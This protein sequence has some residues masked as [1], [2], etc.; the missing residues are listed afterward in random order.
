MRLGALGTI[1]IEDDNGNTIPIT[2]PQPRAVLALLLLSAGHLVSVDRIT[3]VLWPPGAEQP[4]GVK[5]AVQACVSHLRAALKRLDGVR[6]TWHETG[7]ILHVN[8][9]LVDV[10]R[11]REL[12]G[13]ARGDRDPGRRST[14]L[15]EA[16]G[17][18][19]GTKALADV[20]FPELEPEVAGLGEEYA[21]ALECRVQADLDLGREERLVAELVTHTGRHPER[22][23]LRAHL[24]TA[25][26]RCGRTAEASQAYLDYRRWLADEHGTEPGA[27]LR[28]LHTQLL[29]RSNSGDERADTP[30]PTAAGRASYLTVA[31]TVPRVSDLDDPLLLGVHPAPPLT[32]TPQGADDV[33]AYVARDVDADLGSALRRSGFVLVV[34]AATAGKTRAA[35]HAMRTELTDHHVF[36]PDDKAGLTAAVDQAERYDDCVLWLDDLE[37]YLGAGGLTRAEISRFLV[38]GRHRVIL[39]TLR[40]V[41]DSRYQHPT[42]K[43]LLHHAVQALKMARRV[44][45]KRLFSPAERRRAGNL[46]D[47]DPRLARS[48]VT[49]DRYGIAESLAAGPALRDMW[50]AA[51]AE[52]SDQYGA[53]I[54]TAAIDCRRAGLTR[55]LTR[56]LLFELAEPAW[57]RAGMA[58]AQNDEAWTWA[59]RRRLGTVALLSPDGHGGGFTVFEYL[60][61]AVV[62]QTPTPALTTAVLSRMVREAD[63]EEAARLGGTAIEQGEFDIAVAAFDQAYQHQQSELGADHPETLTNRDRR[64]F[65]LRT[66]GLPDHAAGEHRAV[67]NARAAS[68]GAEH[69][70]TL[71][72][73][74]NFGVALYQAGRWP[75]AQAELATVLDARRRVLAEDDPDIGRSLSNLAPVLMDLGRWSEAERLAREAVAFRTRVHGLDDRNTLNSRN[76]LGLVLQ[77]LGHYAEAEAEHATTLDARERLLRPDHPDVLESR[78]NRATALR[79]LD[80]AEEAEREHR[81]VLRLR[82]KMLGEQ[83][84]DTVDARIHL[85]ADLLALGRVAEAA[86]MSELAIAAGTETYGPSH[87]YTLDAHEVH[88]QALIAAGRHLEA[89]DELAALTQLRGRVQGDEHPYTLACELRWAVAR[90]LLGEDIRPVLALLH[91][92]ASRRLDA[93]H[94]LVRAI[95][96][97]L[98]A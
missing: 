76:N 2:K 98:G 65:A 15:A 29:A 42:A 37:H 56:E 73:R 84:Y 57:G 53:A 43:D 36:A 82:E 9:A 49:A 20:A 16:L 97:A 66:A 55:P 69:P 70:L 45:L 90:S 80:R 85:A 34:G 88:A 50:L 17:L 5:N 79:H 32:G 78:H 24:L 89:A 51:Q 12:V 72:S 46:A 21:D 95:I 91:T 40:L 74:N 59:T 6:I 14:L 38:P 81:D 48:L 3:R 61:D 27:E 26:H 23:R 18:W 28:Q 1:L 93:D 77:A 52:G 96:S 7:Y 44:A 47:D 13:Q 58:P 75:E 94:P 8:R 41:E 22:E 54:V 92:R 19:R 33:P 39:S 62:A 10:Y 25:L 87:P 60:V 63:T 71:T 64:A 35:Y 31:G 86:E 30:S 4:E 68:L 83:H 11:F 67:L